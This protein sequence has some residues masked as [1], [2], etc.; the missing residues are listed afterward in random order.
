MPVVLSRHQQESPPPLVQHEAM[1]QPRQGEEVLCEEEDGVRLLQ[2]GDDCALFS[3]HQGFGV[4]AAAGVESD[5]V[6]PER[7]DDDLSVWS[8]R[9]QVAVLNKH[10]HEIVIME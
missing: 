6:V 2:F 7:I 3:T 8:G 5:R 1:R 9:T 10:D 4:S